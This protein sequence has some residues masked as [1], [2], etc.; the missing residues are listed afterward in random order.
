M[1][2]SGLFPHEL[3]AQRLDERHEVGT[4]DWCAPLCLGQDALDRENRH[5][6]LSRH[7]MVDEAKL[8]EPIHGLHRPMV[9]WN[10]GA[11][12]PST[13]RERT[14]ASNDAARGNASGEPESGRR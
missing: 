9:R 12:N 14:I 6:P 8:L 3:L 5:R 10:E 1:R 11:S 13:M 2:S 7:E 4:N